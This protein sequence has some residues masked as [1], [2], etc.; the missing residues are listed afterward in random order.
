MSFSIFEG[1]IVY[2]LR[3]KGEDEMLHYSST[4]ESGSVD[5]FYDNNG[6]KVLMFS[7]KGG[8][9]ADGFV[10]DLQKGKTYIIVETTEMC[11]EG[12]FKFEIIGESN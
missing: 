5:V 1:T 11:T 2:E 4:L 7:V 6:E 9:D 3:C 8:S 12:Q 10:S